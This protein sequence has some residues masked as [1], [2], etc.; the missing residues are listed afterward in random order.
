MATPCFESMG[1]Y[2]FGRI[3]GSKYCLNSKHQCPYWHLFLAIAACFWLTYPFSGI[4]V[5]YRTTLWTL[6]NLV[7]MKYF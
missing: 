2:Y 5:Y 3:F 6:S 4:D 7:G 1:E